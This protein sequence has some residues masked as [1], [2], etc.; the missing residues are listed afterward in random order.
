MTLIHL[1]HLLGFQVNWSKLT[2]SLQ[3]VKFLGI[4][5]DLVAMQASVPEDNIS[6][7]ED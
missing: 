1:L 4:I 3:R 2:G 5:L 7:L 6:E